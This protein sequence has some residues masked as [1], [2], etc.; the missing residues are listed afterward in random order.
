MQ[1]TM[2]KWELAKLVQKGRHALVLRGVSG[3]GKSTLAQFIYNALEGVPHIV[4]ADTYFMQEGVY[5]FDPA[6][7][8]DAHAACLREFTREVQSYPSWNVR[9]LVTA[10][11]PSGP[12]HQVVIVDNTNT[13]VAEAAPYMALAAAYGWTPMLVD[14]EADPR[15]AAARNVHGVSAE[16]VD[17]QFMRLTHA[18]AALP[19]YWRRV[20]LVE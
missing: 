3:A 15:K 9:D 7:L 18:A 14:I 5:R 13:T 10:V 6:K 8:S 19:P 20:T 11:D 4:S 16:T 2:T 1:E 12:S 17:A